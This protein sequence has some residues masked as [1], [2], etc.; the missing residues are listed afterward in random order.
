MFNKKKEYKKQRYP[1]NDKNPNGFLFPVPTPLA[2]F[3]KKYI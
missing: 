1:L 2:S 3:N